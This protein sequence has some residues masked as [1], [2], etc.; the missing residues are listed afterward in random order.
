MS[1]R[2]ADKTMLH[3]LRGVAARGAER[4]VSSRRFRGVVE[5]G[6]KPAHGTAVIDRI[7]E[8]SKREGTK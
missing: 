6:V 7:I 8:T 2:K 4:R 3:R 1:V 5:R